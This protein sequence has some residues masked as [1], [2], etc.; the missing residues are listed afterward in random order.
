M[1][2]L[3]TYLVVSSNNSALQDRPESLNRVGVNRA[4][5]ML[6]NSV[7]D[8]LMRETA[9]Q[10]AIAGISIGAEK[11]NSVR[12]GLSHES[13]KRESVCALDNAGNDIA[14]AL[15]RANDGGLAG[16]SA[17]ARSAF[18]VPMPVLIATA[19]V[20]FVNL[21]NSAKLL[22]VLNHRSSDF[23]AHKPSSFIG[24][25]SHIAEDLKGAHALFAD[26]HKVRDSV[27][28]FQRLIR[29]LKDCA[30]QMRE[31]IAFI[32]AS[33]ALPFKVHRGDFINTR[34]TASW[35]ANALWPT[36]CYQIPDAIILSL[37]QIFELLHSQLVDCFW[38][39]RTAHCGSLTDRNEAL[40]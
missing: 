35:A 19:N 9:L 1:Q 30:G 4:N 15:D 17:P 8:G 29:V 6:A 33:I 20:G 40:A 3:P 11:A 32:G 34:G 2:I 22:D 31:A 14:L 10:A 21:N 13:L 18:L 36:S 24:A 38:M 26:Q 25:E 5:D 16:V 7:I 12:Y 28:I 27:P 23:V 39:F 37:K